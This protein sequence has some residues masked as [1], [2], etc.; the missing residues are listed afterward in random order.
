M[1][2]G[3]GAGEVVAESGL[4]YRAH[5][6]NVGWGSWVT[7]GKTAGT[8]GQS[9]R[10]EALQINP[11][12][13]WELT[14]KVHIQDVG[15]KTYSGIVHGN[16]II[17]GTTGQGRRIEYIQIAVDK[18][19]EGDSRKLYFKVHQEDEGWKSWTEEGMASGSDG[20]SLRLEAIQIKIQ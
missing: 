15:W 1:C 17:I 18:R 8:T 6:Q 11:P 10:L 12:E 4:T 5:S 14:V 7:D 13:G 19:P 16:N 2:G 3:Q 9:L 20:M